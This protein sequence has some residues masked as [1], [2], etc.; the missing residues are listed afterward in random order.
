MFSEIKRMSLLQPCLYSVK[1]DGAKVGPGPRDRRPQDLGTQE[2]KSLKP[3]SKFK[4]E[5]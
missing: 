3:L 2:F 4:S 1:W 5:T